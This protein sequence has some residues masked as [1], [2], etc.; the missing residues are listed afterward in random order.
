MQ[1]NSWSISLEHVDDSFHVVKLQVDFLEDVDN[2]FH[3]AKSLA[4][5]FGTCGQLF[6]ASESLI[7]FF[8]VGGGVWFG[9]VDDYFMPVNPCSISHEHADG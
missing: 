5:F 7:D 6:R 9:P 4:D 3:G 1:L 8:F 2:Y